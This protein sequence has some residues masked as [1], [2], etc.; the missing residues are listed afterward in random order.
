MN[1]FDALYINSFGGKTILESIIDQIIAKNKKAFFFIFDSRL[2]PEV[3]NNI[4]SKNYRILQPNENERKIFYL[5]NKYNFDSFI[6]LS[7]IPPPIRIKDKKVFILFH[8]VLFLGSDIKNQSLKTILINYLKRLYIIFKNQKSYIWITQTSLVKKRLQKSL[9]ISKNQISVYPFFKEESVSYDREKNI[10]NFVY[11]SS[12]VPHKNHI[13]LIKAFTIAANKTDKEIK[14]HLTINE[15][16]LSKKIYPNNL[17]V[18][19]HGIISQVD[20]NLLYDSNEFAI[21]P[22]L[23]ESFGLPLIEATNHGCKVISSDLPYVHE[24]IVPSLA[25][26]PY[27][28]ESISNAILKATQKDNLPE[29]KVLVEN[30]LNNFIKFIISQDV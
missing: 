24:I 16:E 29:T 22:S 17:K 4:S 1:L 21:Y 19:F 10:N 2:D 25:F 9:R 3:Y 28:S 27:S 5:K 18:K 30:K 23:L 8:N 6:C 20:V 7:N 14:L 13:T 26:D 15:E 12:G 11:V